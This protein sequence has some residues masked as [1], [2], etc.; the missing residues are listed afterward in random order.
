MSAQAF[1][2]SR[3]QFYNLQ[4]DARILSFRLAPGWAPDARS[5]VSLKCGQDF[6]RFRSWHMEHGDKVGGEVIVVNFGQT[7]EATAGPQAVRWG[8]ENGLASASWN[9]VL[10]IVDREPN[11]ASKTGKQSR[12]VGIISTRSAPYTG[13]RRG[14]DLLGP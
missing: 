3:E 11:F 6:P 1:A 14:N 12:I 9:D 4:P 5:I 8:L 2:Q 10:R 13:N 7:L